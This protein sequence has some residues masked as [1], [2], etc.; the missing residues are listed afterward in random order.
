VR[1]IV[2]GEKRDKNG[3]IVE[4]NVPFRSIVFLRMTIWVVRINSTVYN[5]KE[6]DEDDGQKE[7]FHVFFS[8]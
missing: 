5:T 1:R 6:S 2:N 8:L 3:N 7:D 4:L